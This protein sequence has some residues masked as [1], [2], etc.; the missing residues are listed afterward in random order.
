MAEKMLW[1]YKMYVRSLR[2][3]KSNVWASIASANLLTL[4]R[5]AT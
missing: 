3:F 5:V 4:A 2:S 1:A